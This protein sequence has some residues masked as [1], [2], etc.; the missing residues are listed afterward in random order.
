MRLRHLPLALLLF[1][2]LVSAQA[3]DM[4]IEPSSLAPPPGELLAVALKVGHPGAEVE[5][6]PRNPTRIVRFAAV[7]AGAEASILGQDGQTPAGVL[8]PLGPGLVTLLYRS[9]VARSELPADR[10]EAYLAE[11][12]LHSIAALRRE[13]GQS[14][15]PGRERYSRCLK[16]LVNVGGHAAE[17]DRWQGMTLELVAETNPFHLE[18]GSSLPVRLLYE[19]NPLPGA[20][21]EA[22]ALDGKSADLKAVS[23]ARGRIAL[24]LPRGGAW[25]LAATHMVSLPAGSDV[26]WESFWASLTFSVPTP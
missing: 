24:R 5:V 3:H 26:D 25:V 6:V 14:L 13:A 10:F 11:E 20:L 2:F 18:P 4:W 7:S 23:D 16:A 15:Q 12:G 21:V 1:G 19:G 22:F 17:A 8:R 9:N